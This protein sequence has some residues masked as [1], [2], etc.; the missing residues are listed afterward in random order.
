MFSGAL[1]SDGSVWMWGYDKWG[2]LGIGSTSNMRTPQRVAL[3]AP[4]TQLYV[5]GDYPNDGHVL[6]HLNDDEVMA[7]G[8]NGNGQLGIG[9]VGGISSTPVPVAVPVGTT[10][11]LVVAGGADSFAVDSAGKLWAWG[12]RVGAGDL[13][14]GTRDGDIALPKAIGLGFSLVSS[15]A[16]E[17]VGF[18]TGPMLSGRHRHHRN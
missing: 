17:A 9:T 14:D 5:G 16:N 13:G 4:A 8:N 15:T 1:E 18:A 11:S 10:F 6:V 12:G 2:Q 3:P 7:W